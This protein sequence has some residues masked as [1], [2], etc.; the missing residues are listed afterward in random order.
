MVLALRRDRHPLRIR[1]L[2]EKYRRR[3]RDKHEL[4]DLFHRAHT[5]KDQ[6]VA[7]GY[8][9]GAAKADG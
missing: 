9:S 7:A 5:V 8:G 2:P 1:G 3:I 6:R 4:M